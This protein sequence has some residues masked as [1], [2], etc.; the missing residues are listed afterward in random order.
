MP[1]AG[2]KI[3]MTYA[4][5]AR[6]R[7][8]LAL[9]IGCRRGVAIEVIESAVAAALGELCLNDLTRIATV[10]SKA[11]EPALLKFAARHGI[12][13]VTFSI[14][15]I[16]RFLREHEGLARSSIVR[17][18]VGAGSVCEPCALLAVPGGYL[19]SAKRAQDGVTVAIAAASEPIP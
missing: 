8:V 11:S 6:S 1:L 3:D 2:A 9:G 13:L 5:S 14:E 12:A 19:V 16:E 15:E 7:P 10:A 17:R 4:S 18:H